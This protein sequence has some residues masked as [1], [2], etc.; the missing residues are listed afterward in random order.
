MIRIWS[1]KEEQKMKDRFNYEPVTGELIKKDFEGAR[2]V[3]K[4]ISPNFDKDGYKRVGIDGVTYKAHRVCFFLYH[5]RQ[6]LGQIDHE[7]R[8]VANNKISN[9]L[10]TT[11]SANQYNRRLLPSNKTGMAG[12]SIGKAGRFEV[13]LSNQYVGSSMDIDIAIEMRKYVEKYKGR[14]ITKQELIDIRLKY[15]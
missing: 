14:L 10:D 12:I 11:V 13:K 3:G 15:K 9:L 1:K 7:D 8:N 5:K 6:C 4:P 2:G